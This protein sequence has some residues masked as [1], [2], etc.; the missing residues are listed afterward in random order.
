MEKREERKRQHFRPNKNKCW[1][2]FITKN[3]VMQINTYFPLPKSRSLMYSEDRQAKSNLSGVQ[4]PSPTLTHTSTPSP[5]ALG[6]YTK[7][8][9]VFVL[10]SLLPRPLT[11][12]HHEHHGQM[13]KWCYSQQHMAPLTCFKRHREKSLKNEKNHSETGL[14]IFFVVKTLQHLE[15]DKP[16]IVVARGTVD[17]WHWTGSGYM[18]EES[19]RVLKEKKKERQT[20]YTIIHESSIALPQSLTFNCP[21]GESSYTHRDREREN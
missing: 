11:L 13:K 7:S 18:L 3:I 9:F 4:I 8:L 10:K 6:K 19:Q 20:N 15:D 2:R 17:N 1:G 14:Y 5:T 12:K 16:G 21:K